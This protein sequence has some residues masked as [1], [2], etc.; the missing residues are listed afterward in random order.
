MEKWGQEKREEKW[1]KMGPVPVFC[2]HFLIPSIMYNNGA[3]PHFIP[4]APFY[5][6]PHF[7]DRKYLRAIRIPQ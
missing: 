6:W 4:V 7:I 5:S 2:P 3:W 1:G